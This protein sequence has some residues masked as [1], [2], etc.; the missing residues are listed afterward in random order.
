MKEV[1]CQA[2]EAR[3]GCVG[4]MNKVCCEWKWTELWPQTGF[5]GWVEA[6][7]AGDINDWCVNLG[8]DL[9]TL[10]VDA[11]VKRN[12]FVDGEAAKSDRIALVWGCYSLEDFMCTAWACDFTRE[13]YDVM[14]LW[15][16]SRRRDGKS[17]APRTRGTI[18]KRFQCGMVMFT[19]RVKF[20]T[21]QT[22]LSRTEWRGPVM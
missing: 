18:P 2:G 17:I 8:D 12:A 20:K 15:W 21:M 22:W 16:C 13:P 3:R 9:F 10:V 14:A 7:V 5:M 4:F 11:A 19:W 6:P 1:V